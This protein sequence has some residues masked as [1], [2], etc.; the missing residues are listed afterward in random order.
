MS[1]AAKTNSKPVIMCVDDEKV[2][3]DSLI[4]QL[5]YHLGD[6]F[7]VEIAQSGDEALEL[8]SE[9]LDEGNDVA[10]VISDQLMPGLK[11][12]ELLIKLHQLKP[13]MLKIL[14]TGQA[15]AEAVGRAIN[16]AKLYRFIS[17]PWD[18]NDLLLTIEEAVNSY[19][20]SRQISMKN[21][22][23]AG[24]FHAGQELNRITQVDKLCQQITR[25]LVEN[26]G[27]ER[28]SVVL[29]DD[30]QQGAAF[31]LDAFGR[32]E[33]IR[34]KMGEANDRVP[35]VVLGQA[36]THEQLLVVDKGMSPP[37]DTDPYVQTFNPGSMCC[38]PLLHDSELIG[39]LYLE[40]TSDTG[41]FTAERVEFVNLFAQQAAVSLANARL[42]EQ[43]EQKVE[44]RTKEVTAQKEI[45]EEKNRDILD[46]I[47]YASRI[48]QA[49]LP[50]PEVATDNFRDFLLMYRPKD[51]IS[52]DFY[53]L[54]QVA[55][56]VV[57]AAVDCTGHGVP[58]AMLATL[59][60]N[61]LDNLVLQDPQAAPGCILNALNERVKRR[62]RKDADGR[63]SA[64]GMD[65]ALASY[66][67]ET[68]TLHYAGANRN[69]YILRKGEMLEYKADRWPIG[70]SLLHTGEHEF[71]TQS[72]QLEA[73]DRCFIFS[74]GITD[75]FCKKNEQKFGIKRL[76]EFIIRQK[77]VSLSVLE[78]TLDMAI[79]QW[80]G[81]QPQTDDILVIG[82]DI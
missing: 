5:N 23:T 55:D 27:A 61:M 16:Q 41:Y 50:N 65:I 46:S 2:V 36:A 80:R 28:C 78:N 34:F 14:L 26:T 43:L 60:Y 77:Q 75:Q 52:G 33:A 70:G 62:L 22:L 48:Q 35:V 37:W 58:G 68:Q 31:T 20:Q 63:Q 66:E 32:Q 1:K 25:L 6:E 4:S 10:L 29:M 3:L 45:I 54:N 73:G 39:L 64:D 30:A 76:K 79:E 67:P 11:G 19:K 53:Y 42:L 7:E 44:I 47:L 17:K 38:L 13:E 82:F 72:I 15:S 21:Q 9:L 40:R 81:T 56:R 8:F 71:S 49:I 12:D 74:D 57:L 51:I 18:K 24:I 69:L 59:G